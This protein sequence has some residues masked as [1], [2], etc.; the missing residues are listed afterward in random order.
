MVINYDI[1]QISLKFDYVSPF[2]LKKPFVYFFSNISMRGRYGVNKIQ[3]QQNYLVKIIISFPLINTK[4][5]PL[6]K[7]LY[8]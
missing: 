2:D 5:P 1:P 8:L 3:T 7:Q 4:L 6:Y